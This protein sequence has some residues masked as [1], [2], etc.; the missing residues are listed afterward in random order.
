MRKI[1]IAPTFASYHFLKCWIPNVINTL[2]PDI[3]ILN[4]G[5]FPQGPENKGHIDRIFK[6]KYC[7]ND[8]MAGFDWDETL[9][10]IK[11]GWKV[12]E[13]PKL[14]KTV[15]IRLHRMEYKGTDA[16]KC[17][18]ESI[19]YTTTDNPFN[20]DLTS[21]DVIFPLE[22]D[23]FLLESD[24]DIINEMIG[25][26]KPG[27]GISCKW[28]D[29]LETQYYTE[30]INLTQPKYRRFC[31][32]YD[33]MENYLKAMDGFMTQNYPLLKKTEDFFIRHYC[34]F[35]PEP[36]KQL[37]FDLIY[38]SNPEYWEDFD[39]GLSDIREVSER[40]KLNEH[41]A[42]YEPWNFDTSLS[43]AKYRKIVVRPSRN[44]EGRWA[45][46]IDIEHPEAIKNH[47]NYIK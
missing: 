37:R 20:F 45:E 4:E 1:V 27:E 30:A 15:S 10:F 28:V 29:F 34:W 25:K 5:L 41:Y 47:E 17:F 36:Y 42:S 6:S 8:T 3:I 33:N 9:E 11:N 18:L 14:S 19:R 32:C 38:R 35:Q 2:D 43:F 21:G 16:N 44:D 46:F 40:L 22:P 31:Y 24:G 13:Y 26:L 7:F 39:K 12:L 23:A